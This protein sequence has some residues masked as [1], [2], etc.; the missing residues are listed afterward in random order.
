M[1]PFK[2]HVTKQIRLR[3]A[4]LSY[5]EALRGEWKRPSASNSGFGE[6]ELEK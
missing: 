4:Q 6:M 1:G 5:E 2:N 3:F